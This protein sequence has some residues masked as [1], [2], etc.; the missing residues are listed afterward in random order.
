MF[1]I[2]RFALRLYLDYG[3]NYDFFVDLWAKYDRP[4][5]RLPSVGNSLIHS[6]Y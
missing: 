1:R 5:N 2:L 3:L 6:L 4:P